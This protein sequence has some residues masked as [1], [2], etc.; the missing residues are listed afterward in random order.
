MT[1]KLGKETIETVY[2]FD[3]KFSAKE[4]KM[5]KE[6]GLELIQKDEASLINYAV[7]RILERA[8]EDRKLS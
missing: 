8:V 6:Y 5:L 4:S 1:M 2:K 7:N 3:A